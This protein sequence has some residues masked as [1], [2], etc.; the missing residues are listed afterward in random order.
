MKWLSLA[1]LI[2]SISCRPSTNGRLNQEELPGSGFIEID[3]G[4]L[5]YVVEGEGIPCLVIGSSVYYPKTFSA[6][7]RKHLRMYFVDMPWFAEEY[8]APDL[9]AYSIQH[10]ANDI[11]EV[12][13]ALK[14]VDF[15]IMGHSIHG[16]VALE[17]ARRYHKHVSHCILIGSPTIYNNEEYDIA[18]KAI[19]KTASQERQELQ[20]KNWM[21]L[22]G[23]DSLSGSE[24]VVENYIAMAPKYW[25]NPRYDARWLWDDMI[26][27]ADIITH[28]YETIFG[29]YNMFRN[30]PTVPVPTFVALGRY[31]YVIP[32][33]F[34]KDQ[35]HIPN[36]TLKVFE[37]SGHTAQFEEPGEFDKKILEWLKIEVH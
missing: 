11:E 14:L 8:S 36:L 33:Q 31:D 23:T 15:V 4:K 34:W 5:K 6:N 32:I 2:I 28:L 21:E 24:L 12:R 10:L 22:Q 26:I 19:W 37:R 27:N 3:G 30:N 25:F 35:T 1:V 13:V 17:Y 29:D 18:T 16:T 9:E 20:N 7:L